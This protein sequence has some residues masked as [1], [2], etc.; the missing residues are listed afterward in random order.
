MLTH[1]QVEHYGL[2]QTADLA[3]YP[4]LTVIT[5][6]TGSG[7]TLFLESIRLIL[8]ERLAKPLGFGESGATITAHFE[9][10]AL[11]EAQAFVLSQDLPLYE[12]ECIIRRHID[13]QGRSRCYLNGVSVTQQQLKNLATF[14]VHE[15]GQHQHHD[16][17]KPTLQRQWL[18]AYGQYQPL[19][20][21]VL[22]HFQAFQSHQKALESFLQSANYR[23]GDRK[24]L[25][26]Q[27]EELQNLSLT[28]T[29]VATLEMEHAQ[30]LNAGTHQETL[31]KAALFLGDESSGA[32]H[33]LRQA[34]KVLSAEPSHAFS[35]SILETLERLQIELHEV[36]QS[37]CD[38][39]LY[40]ELNPERCALVEKRLNQIYDVARKHRVKAKELYAH[41][42]ELEAAL[43]MLQNRS[44]QEAE[45]TQKIEEARQNYI[46]AAQ[47]LSLARQKAA[48]T[49]EKA[50]TRSMQDL[51]MK[52]GRCKILIE[53]H[54]DFMNE[55][56]I[57]KIEFLASTHAH[58]E[59][60]SIAKIASGGELARL[61]L[62]IQSITAT[63][64]GTPTLLFDEIDVGVGGKTGAL[65]GKAL[66]ALSQKTQVICITHLPQVAAFGEHHLEI[67]KNTQGP[68][69]ESHIH[70]VHD[71]ARERELAR[72]LG[73]EEISD[74]ALANA[75]HLL[76]S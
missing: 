16:L 52:G 12:G 42:L 11:K 10:S 57:D 17:F 76:E 53:S 70:Y 4:G 65:I 61:A 24:L 40:S 45:L 33:A 47:Q 21:D 32:Q 2:I 49:L 38:A 74:E 9:L 56:G 69:A 63:S 6:E 14:L 62:C 20:N 41:A 75:R 55:E 28:E 73:G 48:K 60:L 50:I 35:V 3:F 1:L 31:Q 68:S 26:Y 58:Q 51:N 13:T 19:L 5:G 71:E 64:K 22:S 8:G 44:Q 34:I 43:Y 66:K 27:V 18:D 36:E 72:M 54:L 25:E 39:A 37:L 7:K 67:S 29:E 59:P 30:L 46:A 23:E 15:H